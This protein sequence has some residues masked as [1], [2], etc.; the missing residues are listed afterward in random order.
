MLFVKLLKNELRYHLNNAM[1]K[2]RLQI[3]AAALVLFM[4]DGL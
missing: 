4:A 1:Y 3:L 2:N